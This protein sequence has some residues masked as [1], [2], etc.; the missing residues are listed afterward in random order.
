MAAILGLVSGNTF[1]SPSYHNRNNRRRIFHDYPVGQ[2]PLTGLLSLMDAEETDSPEFGWFEKRLQTPAT[3]IASPGSSGL[4]FRLTTVST[5][6]DTTLTSPYT[7]LKDDAQIYRVIVAS[8]AGFMVRD[9]LLILDL[10]G[11]N[12]TLVT[13]KGIIT[14]VGTGY[15]EFIM[16]EA[17]VG[18]VNHTSNTYAA[19]T[20]PIGAPVQTAGSAYGEAATSGSGRFYLPINPKNNTQIFRNAFSF[21]RSAMKV[22]KDFDRTGIY[23][24]T[25]EDNLRQHMIDLEKAFLFGVKDVQVITEGS[26]TVPRR[27]TGGVLWFLEQWEK[28]NSIYRTETTA[29]TDI[30]DPKKRIIQ[31]T[32]GAIT[33]TNL[34]KYIA[35]AFDVTNDRAFE[36][37]V[38]CGNGV[39]SAINTIFETR[40]TL[41]KQFSAQKVYGMN[42]VTWESAFGTLHFKTHPLFTRDAQLNYNALILDVQNLKYRALTD[43]DTTCLENRQAN[44]FDGRKDEWITEAGLEMNFPESCMYIKNLQSITNS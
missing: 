26:E 9:Q 31:S 28:A 33:W 4:P 13:I 3:T 44:D 18:V 34:N 25:A 14:S 30:A 8:S 35:R 17:A 11:A 5:A 16:S 41:Q 42:V 40:S 29:V 32:A 27:T 22:P 38:V 20:G 39:L 15:I 12:S 37:L 19:G 36:K 24:E 10:P 6:G 2:F 21:S 23:R 7:F 43:S 1:A